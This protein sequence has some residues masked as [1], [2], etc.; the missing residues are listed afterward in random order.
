M[1]P[2]SW[3]EW[4]ALRLSFQVSL[5]AVVA[6]LPAAI[7]IGYG[8][9]RWQSRAKWMLEVV[10]NLPLVLPPVVTGLLLLKLFAPIGPIG[11][12]L[13]HWFGVRIVLTWLG[14]AIAAAVMSF[15][16][17]VRAIRLAFQAVDPRLEMAARSLGAGRFDAFASVA[18]PLARSG[19]LAGCVLAFARSLG[20]FGATFMVAGNIVGETQTIPLAIFSYANRPGGEGAVWR[21]A[22]ISIALAAGALLASEWLER[23]QAARETT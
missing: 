1:D 8:L 11:G 23:R 2:L 14:A 5:C 3:E 17:M 10:V 6:S 20:E 22:G 9:A 15:P 18:L 19:V 21:L 12:A 13:E 4:S 16:L 7:A